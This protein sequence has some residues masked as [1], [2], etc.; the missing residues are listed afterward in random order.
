MDKSFTQDILREDTSRHI[1]ECVITL[2]EKLGIQTVA[3]GVETSEQV[4]C[5]QSIG[6]DFFQGY[7]FEKPEQI[8]SPW[9]ADTFLMG[10]IS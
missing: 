6:V 8:K 2:A 9:W 3:E 7:Y 10:T 5:L 4:C 1:I